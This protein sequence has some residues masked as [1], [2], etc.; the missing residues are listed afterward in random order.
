MNNKMYHWSMSRLSEMLSLAINSPCENYKLG[1][2][3][4]KSPIMTYRLSRRLKT[5]L[6]QLFGAKIL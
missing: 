4:L 5:R 1:G 3:A 6:N 2:Y